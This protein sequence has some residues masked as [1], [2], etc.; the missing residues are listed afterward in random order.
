MLVQRLNV[1]EK[2]KLHL[3]TAPEGF[4][5]CLRA[6]HRPPHRFRA[7]VS[8]TADRHLRWVNSLF[9]TFLLWAGELGIAKQLIFRVLGT[10]IL[11][12]ICTPLPY[13]LLWS[14]IFIIGWENYIFAWIKNKPLHF[15]HSS[16]GNGFLFYVI[17]LKWIWQCTAHLVGLKYPF[18][19][20]VMW[21]NDLK[22][23]YFLWVSMLPVPLKLDWNG[24][25]IL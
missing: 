7:A 4:S 20:T 13:L 9:C 14:D 5:W 12:E 24:G 8:D 6:A 25:W 17:M 2:L 18:A 11:D 15:M 21:T 22:E 1:C 23:S 10:I 16:H 3:P 19:I